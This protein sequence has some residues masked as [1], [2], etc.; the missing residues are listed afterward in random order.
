M[1][2]SGSFSFGARIELRITSVSLVPQ[3]ERMLQIA[4]YVIDIP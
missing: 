3:F 1:I 2:G 4:R